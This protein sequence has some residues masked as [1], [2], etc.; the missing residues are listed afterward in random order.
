MADSQVPHWI[1]QACGM[2]FWRPS[3][4]RYGTMATHASFAGGP[5][6]VIIASV[7]T[8]RTEETDDADALLLVFVLGLCSGWLC[9]GSRVLNGHTFTLPD[10]FVIEVAAK[11]PLVDRPITMDFDERGRLYV[12]DSSGSNEPT[13]KQLENPTHRIRRLEDVDADG[14]YDKSTL[15]ADKMMSP[16]GRCGTTV[17]VCG[18]SASDL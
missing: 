14:V 3:R 12:T 17:A 5:S 8:D 13:A 6:R 4:Q 1:H 10:G 11:A 15:F 2:R 7:D 16:R 9:A 18:C